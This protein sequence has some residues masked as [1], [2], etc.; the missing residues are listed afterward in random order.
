MAYKR[1]AQGGRF[2]RGEFGD[3]GLRAYADA[4]NREI[5]VAEEQRQQEQQ[6]S[7]QHLQQIEGTGSKQIQHNRMLQ[8]LTED[9]GQLALNNT[10]LRGKREVEEILGRAK[11]AEKESEFWKNFSTTYAG[12]YAKAAGELYDFATEIQH[13]RQMDAFRKNPNAQ[14]AMNEFGHLNELANKNLAVDAYKAFRDKG[15]SE[16]NARS[17]VLAQY[18]D[19]GLRMNH[20]TKM[21]LANMI[22]KKWSGQEALIREE[23]REAKIEPT[24]ENIDEYYKL[25]GHE[26]LTEFGISPTSIAGRHLLN[27][28]FDKSLDKGIEANNLDIANNHINIHARQKTQ[29]QNLISKIKFAKDPKT[30]LQTAT[31]DSV[32]NFVSSWQQMVLHHATMYRIDN[33]GNVIEPKYGSKPNLALSHQILGVE[34]IEAGY[35]NSWDQIQNHL[36]NTP[37]LDEKNPYKIV[38]VGNE[39]TI[40]FKEKEVWGKN[41]SHREV[42]EQAWKE[43]KLKIATEAAQEQAAT[44]ELALIEIDDRRQLDPSDPNYFDAK[45]PEHITKALE[46]YD[47]KEKTTKMLRD[48]QTFNQFDK[49]STVVNQALH[50]L[51]KDADLP[52][53]T[54]YIRHLDGEEKEIWTGRKNQLALLDRVGLDQQGLR[55]QESMYLNMII[56]DESI[57]KDLSLYVNTRNDIRQEIIKQLDII[58]SNETESK[59]GDQAKLALIDK[60]IREQM[61]LDGPGRTDAEGET[62]RGYGIFRRKGEKLKT[63]FLVHDQTETSEATLNQIKEKLKEKAGWNTLFLQLADPKNKGTIT[64]KDKGVEVSLRPIS[65]DDADALIRA[66]DGGYPI[67]P[68]ETIKWLVENQPNRLD[69]KPLLKE[70]E[71][72][73]LILRGL[74]VRKEIP[75]GGREFA[76]YIINTGLSNIPPEEGNAV[77]DGQ[78]LNPKQPEISFI[79]IDRYSTANRVAC[80][81]YAQCVRSGLVAAGHNAQRDEWNK[82]RETI[83]Q[84]LTT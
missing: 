7:R 6:Y 57:K 72:T 70:R 11:E 61:E 25:R 59:L 36:I 35:F 78:E 50:A 21:A 54:E 69:G 34:F 10:K 46:T 48:F 60:R 44:D 14:K 62:Y 71:M 82:R 51:W 39:T 17:M 43:R 74:G 30:G 83:Q 24:R 64:V 26:L 53:L 65:L 4:R 56:N 76:D 81:V 37:L 75:Q 18:S 2:K 9:V 80:S 20:K 13:Q 47:G 23:M 12:Q 58:E 73:N 63:K 19:L 45:N 29:V 84:L 8:D 22:L 15:I 32:G 77:I 41:I 67:P 79:G 27:G 40:S 1:H 33:G 38:Q 5:K 68:N 49:K 55:N 42:F 3:L 16:A 52:N 66:V 31:G 28:I